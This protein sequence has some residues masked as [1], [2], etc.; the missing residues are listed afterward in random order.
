MQ[1]LIVLAHRSDLEVQ[2]M[3]KM[4]ASKQADWINM[5]T[6]LLRYQHK[7]IWSKTNVEMRCIEKAVMSYLYARDRMRSVVIARAPLQI[8]V[9]S[10]AQSTFTPTVSLGAVSDHDSAVYETVAVDVDAVM[11]KSAGKLACI[12]RTSFQVSYHSVPLCALPHAITP[13]EHS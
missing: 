2:H 9:Q 6:Q 1:P 7:E 13:I 8:R 10:G 11:P 5:R 4:E 12:T 3:N